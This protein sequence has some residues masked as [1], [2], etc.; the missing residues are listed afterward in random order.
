MASKKP[1]KKDV[2]KTSTQN[3]FNAP[4]YLSDVG[5][6][7]YNQLYELLES[8]K[9]I[10]PSDVVAL[11]I[12]CVNYE[13]YIDLH[14]AMISESTDGTVKGYFIGRNSQTMAEFNGYYKTQQTVIRLLNEFGLTPKSRKNITIEQNDEVTDPI[15]SLINS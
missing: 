10:T 2:K 7:K 9:V 6:A 14:N 11:E 1:I 5:K 3:K 8:Q 4:E 15:T 13:M 12:L